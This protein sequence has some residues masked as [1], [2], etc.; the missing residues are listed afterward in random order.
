MEPLGQAQPGVEQRA[1]QAV[2]SACHLADTTGPGAWSTAAAEDTLDAIDTLT[3]ALGTIGPEI[4]EALAAVAA[5][6]T[7]ARRRLGIA[8]DAE[9]ET[10]AP[11]VPIAPRTASRIRR[12]GLGPGFQGVRTGR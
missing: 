4:T 6:T 3:E 7:Q 2:E 8:V 11:V 12:R 5:A 9:P 10:T 1:E